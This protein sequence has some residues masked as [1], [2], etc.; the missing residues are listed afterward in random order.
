M[1]PEQNARAERQSQHRHAASCGRL[2][3][4]QRLQLQPP[5]R[6]R[7][8]QLAIQLLLCRQVLGKQPHT[9]TASTARHYVDQVPKFRAFLLSVY[10]SDD[11]VYGAQETDEGCF[12]GRA[13]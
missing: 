12:D 11:W 8:G 5:C 4:L 13:N 2:A 10:S 1:T 9:R 3:R 7:R 6:H